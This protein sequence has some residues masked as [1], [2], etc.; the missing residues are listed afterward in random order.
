MSTDSEVLAQA[1]AWLESGHAVRLVTVAQT[2]GSSPRPVGSLL[3]IDDRG[4]LCGSV[5]GGC[6]E[7]DLRT[8]LMQGALADTSPTLVSYGVDREQAQRFGLP[9]G[10]RLELLVEHLNSAAQ[11][12]RV[13]HILQTRERIMRRVCLTTGEAS[14]HPEGNSAPFF[15]D[16][17]R[18]E[19]TFGPTWRLLLIGAG[20]LS[21]HVAQMALTL[22]YHVTVCDPRAEY[23]ASWQLTGVDVDTRMP[24]DAVR[25]LACDAHSVVMALTHDPKLDDMALMEAL[26]SAAFYVGALGSRANNQKRRERLA[27]LGVAPQALARLHGPI[28]L[29]IGSR[30]PPE[31][32]IA[33]LAELTAARHG[34]TLHATAYAA[35]DTT[36]VCA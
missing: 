8:R 18:L 31:I 9:C 3:A 30:T 15:Y 6:V 20:H 35:P 2:W 27:Q 22:D 19:K 21:H 29:A 26:E 4:Q 13:L 17:K 10:G 32:A 12:R 25:A 34:I 5:S 16:G 33:I 14:L 1:V 23:A 36:R 11:L 7:D 24:D 28:G